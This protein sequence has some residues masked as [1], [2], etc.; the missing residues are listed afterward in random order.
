MPAGVNIHTRERER[1][2]ERARELKQMEERV[3]DHRHRGD[4]VRGRVGV[5]CRAV[6]FSQHLRQEEGGG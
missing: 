3:Y 1:E 2:R 6:L 5:M 4:T